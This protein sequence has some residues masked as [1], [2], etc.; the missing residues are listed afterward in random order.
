MSKTKKNANKT[1]K[2]AGG[3]VTE[4]ATLDL[5]AVTD[6]LE[7]IEG[8]L[9][10]VAAQLGAKSEVIGMAA[11]AGGSTVRNRMSFRQVKPARIALWRP[12][13]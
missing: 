2:A 13:E 3:V 5:S 9:M 1:R 8:L 7:S 10:L 4:F 6:K 11:G 12:E